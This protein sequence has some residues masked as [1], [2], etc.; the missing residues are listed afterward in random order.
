M[1]PTRIAS[2]VP[3]RSWEHLLRVPDSLK[4][5]PMPRCHKALGK[6]R[7]PSFAAWIRWRAAGATTAL[8]RGVHRTNRHRE[9]SLPRSQ[10]QLVGIRTIRD[11]RVCRFRA[12]LPHSKGILIAEPRKPTAQTPAS[13][14]PSRDRKHR[15]LASWRRH[16]RAKTRPTQA[17]SLNLL[18]LVI[19]LPRPWSRLL[20]RSLVVKWRR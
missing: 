9:W 13:P 11:R 2:S 5:K 7:T 20:L 3:V 6:T 15:Q 10:L 12:C 19:A 8:S 1:V 4:G 18:A 14:E 16:Q 17:L